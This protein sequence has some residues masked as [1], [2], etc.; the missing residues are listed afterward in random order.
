MKEQEI[1]D[2]HECRM[3]HLYSW[4]D[5][6]KVDD[7]TFYYEQLKEY[8]RAKE[9]LVKFGYYKESKQC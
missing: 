5:I 6:E 9:L 1:L 7:R 2:E 4:K 8:E 3:R